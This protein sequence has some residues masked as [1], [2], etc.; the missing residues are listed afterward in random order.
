MKPAGTR[1]I[2]L[3]INGKRYNAL[4]ERPGSARQYRIRIAREAGSEVVQ[5]LREYLGNDLKT[6]EKVFALR[7]S[8][9]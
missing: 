4:I 2:K 9:K 1:K 5:A 7:A 3:K 6:D 8:G